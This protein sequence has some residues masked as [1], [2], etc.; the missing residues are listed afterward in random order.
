MPKQKEN[1]A[2][3]SL[4]DV[5]HPAHGMCAGNYYAPMSDAQYEMWGYQRDLQAK[6]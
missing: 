6:L 4:A 1:E 3:C 2:P 5:A